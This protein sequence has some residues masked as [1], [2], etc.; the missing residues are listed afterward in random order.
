MKIII[1]GSMFFYP[2]FEKLKTQL[3]KQGH[4]VK[5]PLPDE[6]YKGSQVKKEA[7]KDFN[8]NLEQSDAILVANYEKN[9]KP[10]YIGINSIMEIGMAFNKN[11]KIFILFQIPENCKEEFEAIGVVE[12][13]NNLNLIK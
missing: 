1:T 5:I 12:L 11:K 2:E 7:M 9:K 3:E 8:K 10:N 4:E 6:F 13:N